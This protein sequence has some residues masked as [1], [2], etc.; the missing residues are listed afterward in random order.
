MRKLSPLQRHR[1]ELMWQAVGFFVG[2]MMFV[3]LVLVY[4]VADGMVT[5]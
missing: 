2:G 3:A 4:L 5:R 1:R